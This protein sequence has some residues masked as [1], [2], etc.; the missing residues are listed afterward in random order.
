MSPI[1]IKTL[2]L[3]GVAAVWVFGYL[4]GRAEGRK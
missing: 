2:F 3:A 4:I 1:W